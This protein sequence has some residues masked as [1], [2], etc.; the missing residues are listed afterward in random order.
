M[1]RHCE[2]CCNILSDALLNLCCNNENFFCHNR[3]FP[4]QI[5]SKVDYF[6]IERKY[7][8]TQKICMLK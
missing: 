8:A 6:A 1:S 3:N 5:E 2:K 7:A 4:F